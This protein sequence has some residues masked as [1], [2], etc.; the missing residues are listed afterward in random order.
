MRWRVVTGRQGASLCT[1]QMTE[2]IKERARKKDMDGA[3]VLNK[4]AI[5]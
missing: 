1:S 3:K 2:R 4:D 5:T